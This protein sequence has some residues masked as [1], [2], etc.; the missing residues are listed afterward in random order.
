MGDT[1]QPKIAVKIHETYS[2]LKRAGRYASA[3]LLDALLPPACP[4]TG[5]P[6]SAP[7]TLSPQGWAQIQFIDDPVCARCGVPFA[8]D[9]GDGAQ[10]AA[11]MADPPSFESARAAVLY[12]DASHK[13]I[14]AYKHAD[15]TD[16]A[17][18]LGAWIARAG[19]PIVSSQTILVPTPLHPKRL[20][21]RRFNQA[22][23]IAKIASAHL[24]C[25]YDPMILQRIKPTPPQKDLSAD[26]RKRN[27]SGA[28]AVRPESV[29]GIKKAHIVI[30]DDVLT[31]GATV[32]ACARALKKAGAGRIDALVA[33][34]V[35]RHGQ[36]AI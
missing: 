22:A 11:C 4:I 27:V 33:A 19:A 36:D 9:Y 18:M 13:L 30:V 26:A 32:S 14:V 15:R 5:D 1:R 35:V 34:R 25:R 7:G 12:D 23:M 21:A 24:R 28:F 16:Y 10:C 20:A 17:P 6:V 8:H 31:T 2:L 29:D 3:S